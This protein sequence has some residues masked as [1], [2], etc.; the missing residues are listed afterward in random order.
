MPL[1]VTLT[2]NSAHLWI[3]LK[4][5]DYQDG[6]IGRHVGNEKLGGTR[7]HNRSESVGNWH[8]KSSIGGRP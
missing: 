4:P 6:D 8:I 2:N 5:A 3:V 7:R 1:T